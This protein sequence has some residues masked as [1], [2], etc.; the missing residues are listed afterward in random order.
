MAD[1]DSSLDLTKSD[2]SSG[3]NV[4]IAKILSTYSIKNRSTIKYYYLKKNAQLCYI[5]SLIENI[6]YFESTVNFK[7]RLFIQIFYF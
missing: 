2:E 7:R 3:N 4:I 1:L 5:L 6:I